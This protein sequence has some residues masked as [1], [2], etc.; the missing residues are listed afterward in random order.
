MTCFIIWSL[1]ASAINIY[2]YIE[3]AD[4]GINSISQMGYYRDMIGKQAVAEQPLK[5]AK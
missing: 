2:P 1:Y 5:K 4:V 3:K